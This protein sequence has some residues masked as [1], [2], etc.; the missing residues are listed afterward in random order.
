MQIKINM[1]LLVCKN[2]AGFILPLG[3]IFFNFLQQSKLRSDI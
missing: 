2:N 3:F 1:S